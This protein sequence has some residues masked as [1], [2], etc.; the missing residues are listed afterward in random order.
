MPIGAIHTGV[1]KLTEND[2][3]W[4]KV[5]DGLFMIDAQMFGEPEN[6]STYVIP[7][8]IPTL[9]EPGPT[10]CHDAVMAGLDAMGIDEIAQVVVTHI[11]L[12]HAGGAGNMLKRFPNA[13]V[14]VHERGAS[15]LHDPSRLLRSATRIYGAEG[16]RTLWGEMT[17]IESARLHAVDEGDRIDIGPNRWLDVMYTPGHANH[18]MSL[19]DSTT[20]IVMIGDSVGITFPDTNIVH[21]PVPPPDI[22]VELMIS[23]FY[24]YRERAV[25][26]LGFAHFG[27]KSNVDHILD[28]AERR[29]RLWTSIADKYQDESPA[30]VGRRIEIANAAD[31]RAC[32]HRD[33]E[34]ERT[35]R[36]TSFATEA[37]GLLRYV[38][39]HRPHPH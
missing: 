1:P 7:D 17:P 38:H 37:S 32:G 33:E 16:L 2:N 34:I 31:L 21:P 13:E 20:G 22:D 10:T 35:T 19:I 26:A 14:F 12:D 28:E 6:L 25:P 4:S 11:H 18:H 8:P 27:L 29:L 5:G 30:E 36:R 15:H 23:Q 9:I 3:S 39:R 24:R